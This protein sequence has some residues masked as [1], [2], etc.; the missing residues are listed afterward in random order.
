MK[1]K[2]LLSGSSG[3]IGS[4]IYEELK[5]DN[6]IILIGREKPQNTECD[7]YYADFTNYYSVNGAMSERVLIDHPDIDTF[8]NASGI[9]GKIEKSWNIQQKDFDKCMQVNFYTPMKI[10]NYLIPYFKINKGKIILFSGGGATSARPD[11]MPYSISKTAIVRYVENLDAE[12]KGTDICINA[13]APDSH[14]SKMTRDALLGTMVTKNE[15]EYKNIIDLWKT[16]NSSSETRE[17]IDKV[18]LLIRLL[19]E[20]EISGR[21]L[22]AKWDNFEYLKN[23]NL[24]ENQY[25]L[26]RITNKDWSI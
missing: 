13:I 26:R 19:L 9:Q 6:T 8:I 23:N 1:R 2:I 24:S 3:T 14:Y 11:F 15:K 22:S 18:I 12:L 10:I 7:W 4:A 17:K 5:R 20:S 25:K 16:S 21:L